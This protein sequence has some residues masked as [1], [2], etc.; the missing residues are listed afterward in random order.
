MA[1]RRRDYLDVT[2]FPPHMQSGRNE[3]SVSNTPVSVKRFIQ[4]KVF[5]ALPGKVASKAQKGG[6]VNPVHMLCVLHV[7]AQVE[8]SQQ[9]LGCFFLSCNI[10]RKKEDFSSFLESSGTVTP[11]GSIS[12][13][14]L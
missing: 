4:H 6:D 13:T 10:E 11:P 14:T 12:M 8:L 1:E 9:D 3:D 2:I 7:T 5:I